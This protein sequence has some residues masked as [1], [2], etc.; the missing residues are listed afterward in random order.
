MKN[1]ILLCILV[2]LSCTNTDNQSE[3]KTSS[4]YLDYS[5]RD[6]KLSGG[7]KMIPIETSA[8]TFRVWT[9]R[10]GNNPTIKLLL[11]HGGPA[12]CH[13]NV[14]FGQNEQEIGKIRVI[15]R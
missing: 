4:T 13:R 9:K 7:V 8:G 5:N 6:D 3:E 11:L 14:I 10:V 1:L 15:G 12:N 2:L